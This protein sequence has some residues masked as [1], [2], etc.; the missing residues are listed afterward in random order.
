MKY[1]LFSDVHSNLEAMTVV[2]DAMKN[3]GVARI[4]LPGRFG[5]LLR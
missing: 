1:G 5:R 3:E 4:P 2:A